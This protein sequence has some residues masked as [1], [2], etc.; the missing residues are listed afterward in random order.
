MGYS[1]GISPWTDDLLLQTFSEKTKFV[2]IVLGHDWYPIVGNEISPTPPLQREG[3]S[4]KRYSDAI[5]ISLRTVED[6]AILFMNLYP[7]FRQP[8]APKTGPLE[9]YKQWVK[10]LEAVCK[11]I[12]QQYCLVRIISWGGPVWEALRKK[13]G[14]EWQQLGVRNAVD[15]Q[16]RHGQ[17]EPI[18]L[19]LGGMKI[20]Y[21]AFAH[22]SFATNFKNELHWAAYKSAIKSLVKELSSL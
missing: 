2:I 9:N 8:G 1:L 6:C 3:I 7:D 19:H 17:V 12:S 16:Y 4:D 13:L 22:P 11:S 14:A 5:P 18:D 10:G 21:H 15:R 20:S